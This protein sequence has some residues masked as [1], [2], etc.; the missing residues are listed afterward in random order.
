MDDCE[1][2]VGDV[3]VDAFEVGEEVELD[4]ADFILIVITLE[5]DEMGV[6]ELANLKIDVIL[7]AE[8]FLGQVV[9]AGLEGGVG[10]EHVFQ[11]LFVEVVEL[12]PGVAVE[13]DVEFDFF[14]D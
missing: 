4:G 8:K 6:A 3:G 11:D 13:I 7:V 9:V 12:L 2:D 5:A 1:G 10:E 14:H